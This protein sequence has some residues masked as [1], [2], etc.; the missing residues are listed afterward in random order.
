[1]R[2][3]MLMCAAV[4]IIAMALGSRSQAAQPLASAN[5]GQVEAF[6]PSPS[7][8]W[9]CPAPDAGM[10]GFSEVPGRAVSLTTSG[11]PVLF[12]VNFNVEGS[13]G[14]GFALVLVVDGQP[15]EQEQ[16]SWATF[17]DTFIDIISVHKVY[18][19]PAGSHTFAI[20]LACV[21]TIIVFS[22]RL[23]VYELPLVKK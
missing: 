9:L 15:H 7:G 20:Q 18:Q 13:T 10:G 3:S 4:L 1:M 19:L 11:G 12:M 5:V 22:A 2:K 21:H 6:G 8:G 17:A 16:L 14:A 23:T